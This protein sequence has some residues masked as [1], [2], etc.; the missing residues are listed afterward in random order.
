MDRAP[1]TAAVLVA[2][3]KRLENLPDIDDALCSG[4]IGYDR[5]AAMSRLAGH[6]DA[7]DLLQEAAGSDIAGIRNPATRRRRM[8]R[9]DELDAFAGRYVSIQPNLDESAWYLPGRLPGY[10]GQAVVDALE[11]GADT[12]PHAPG[13]FP[14]CDT[15]NADALRSISLDS[16]QGGDGCRSTPPHRPFRCSSRPPRPRLPTV[17]PVFT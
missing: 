2:A 1:E 9:R 16:L 6:P 3:A 13:T 7:S 15:R 14:L 12:F 5:A 11:T 10:A 8:T 17:R 4:A